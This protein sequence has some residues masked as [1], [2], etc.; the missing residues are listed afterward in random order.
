MVPVR[1]TPKEQSGREAGM[2]NRRF[3]RNVMV[4]GSRVPEFIFL[5][6]YPFSSQN[7]CPSKV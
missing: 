2:K 1:R 5:N 3:C 7:I 4:T 6:A